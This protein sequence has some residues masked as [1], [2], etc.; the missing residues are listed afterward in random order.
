MR[1]LIFCLAACLSTAL[2]AEDTRC[3]AD[4]PC[5]L[6]DRSY[7]VKEPD[8]WD[9]QSPMPVLVHFHGWQRTGALPVKHQ[10]IS[11]AT[12]RRGVLLVAP[13]GLRKT[14]NF[15]SADTE[16]VDFAIRVIEDVV[17]RYPVDRAQ[18]FLSGYSYGSAM[19]W[20]VACDRGAGIR[21]LLAVS[22]TIDQEEDCREAPQ[23]ARHVHGLRDN[24]LR[25]PMGA[26]GDETYPVKLWRDALGCADTVAERRDWS[27]VPFL[28]HSRT[29]WQDCARGI[30]VTLDVHP[31]GHFIPHGWIGR[32]LDELLERPPTYP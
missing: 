24:V 2:W 23:E 20:R 7:H 1:Y 10:R 19:A 3:H 31:G 25:F 26:G 28:T 17:A 30:K 8:S 29:E 16:D 9:G 15:W 27:V 4:V 6:G 11:G 22:G 32:Q 14:W 5:V 21:A 12:R 18:I 13:N